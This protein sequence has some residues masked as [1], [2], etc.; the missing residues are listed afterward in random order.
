V[1]FSPICW[2][3]PNRVS[4]MVSASINDAFLVLIGLTKLTRTADEHTALI[5]RNICRTLYKNEFRFVQRH[6]PIVVEPRS[7]DKRYGLLFA[8]I[9]GEFPTSGVLGECKT[10]FREALDAK[11]KEVEPDVFPELLTG[12]SI[13]PLGVGAYK[14]VP[15]SRGWS[16]DPAL[17]YMDER[18]PYDIIEYWNLRALGWRIKPLPRSLAP[19]LKAFSEKFIVESHR[20]YPPPSNACE[21]ASFLCSR[22][23]PFDEMQKYVASLNR[24]SSFHVSIDWRVPRLW[25]EWGR[26]AD[27]A[28]PQVVEFETES[29]ETSSW[30]NSLSVATIVPEFVQDHSFGTP[31][32]ACTNVLEKL[33]GGAPVIP[34]QMIDVRFLAGQLNLRIFGSV[35]KGFAP[36]PAHTIRVATY[37]CPVL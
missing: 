34:W 21:D 2:L 1:P 4:Q 13:Y 12:R 11:E 28:E 5:L 15:R 6:P 20:P 14:L 10:H 31:R 24:P 33:P 37:D 23:C 16:P 19:K 22:S 3:R 27:H 25:E 17:F 35:E 9:F 26:H 8:A 36:H 18:E 32:H 29:Q 7:T 30:G